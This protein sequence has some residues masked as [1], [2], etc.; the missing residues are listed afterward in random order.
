MPPVVA[1]AAAAVGSAIGAGALGSLTLF[2]IAGFSVTVG[3]VVGSFASLAINTLGSKLFSKSS[4][5]T[6]L[7]A[8]Y[9]GLQTVVRSAVESHKIIYGKARLSG[10]LT[11]FL[12]TEGDDNRP[13]DI[14]HMVISLAGHEIEAIDEI[15]FN[16]TLVTFDGSGYSNSAPYLETSTG[17]IKQKWQSYFKING[18]GQTGNLLSLENVSPYTTLNPSSD[19][20]TQGPQTITL[21]KGWAISYTVGGTEYT[22]AI[23]QD[24][25]SQSDD[26][27]NLPLSDFIGNDKNLIVS[28]TDQSLLKIYSKYKPL[29]KLNKHLGSDTQTA[30]TD[31]IAVSPQWTAAHQGKGIAYIYVRLNYS[32]TAF[33]DG[34][35]QIRCVVRGKKLYDPRTA[36]TAYST[37]AALVAYD[38]LKSTYG[39]GCLDTELNEDAFIESANICDELVL[40]KDGSSQKRYEINGILDTAAQPVDNLNQITAAMSG[41]ATYS[42]GAFEVLA[43]AYVTHTVTVDEDWLRGE[44]SVQARPN[45]QDIFNSIKGVFV[46]NKTWQTTDFPAIQNATYKAQ[47]NNEEIWREVEYGLVNDPTACQRLAKILL[48]KSRQGIVVNMPCNLKALQL[49]VGDVVAV[50]NTILGWAAKPFRVL[51][52][53]FTGDGGIDLILQEDSAASYDWAAGN[54][55]NYDP[56]PDTNLPSPFDIYP[57]ASLTIVE[58]LYEQVGVGVQSRAVLNWADTSSA[59]TIGYDVEYKLATDSQWIPAGRVSTTNTYILGIQKGFYNF[60]VRTANSLG[61]VSEWAYADAEMYGLTAAPAD[62]TGFAVNVIEGT[63]HFTWNQ[64]TDLDVKVGGSIKIRWTHLTTGQAWANGLDVGVAL[65]GIATSY[66]LPLVSGTY[67]IKAVDSSGIESANAAMIETDYPNIYNLNFLAEKV[68]SPSFAGT[69]TNMYASGG[70]LSMDG[71][72][73]FDSIAGNFDDA[74]GQFDL[75]NNTGVQTTGSYQ[76]DGYF[77]QGDVYRSR[78]QILIDFE[79]FKLSDLF[80]STLGLF[81]DK[82]GSFDGEDL[83]GVTITPYIRTTN[84]NPSG[85][86]T[87]SEWRQFIVGDY[88]ARAFQFKIDVTAPDAF[89]SVNITELKAIIDVP[90]RFEQGEDVVVP[91]GGTTITFSKPFFAVPNIGI[92]IQDVDHPTDHYIISNR[93]VN[94]FDVETLHGSSSE[95]HTIDWIAKAY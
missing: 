68:E 81:D 10:Q 64:S 94:G 75:G 13:N 49:K 80:D 18:A 16:E 47:D 65:S 7:A 70:V 15:Y 61:G 88:N 83:S 74:S 89:T 42:Q 84:D 38:Y 79:S 51:S 35:P 55:T 37:N 53:G 26:I 43:G 32:D 40:L 44:L 31:L 60:R 71:V 8:D 46:D 73:L 82:V 58:Q 9:G 91:I 19:A 3:T 69:K 45:R 93:T 52:W 2:S 28:P 5:G 41:I 34:V 77:D 67:M 78:I 76:F 17:E 87:W 62:I 86:P 92:T 20:P 57:P 22:Y 11:Y 1:V 50:N 90:D 63:G 48:E 29:I 25:T 23:K 95:E 12:T 27:F 72:A 14:L 66:A 24:T 36:T 30:D 56:A 33:S 6:N 21:K 4:K 85:S 54:A 59:F 39:F